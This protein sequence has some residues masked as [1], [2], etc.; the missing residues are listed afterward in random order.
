MRAAWLSLFSTLALAP[1]AFSG[2]GST[3]DEPQGSSAGTGGSSVAGAGGAASGNSASGG[4]GN[5]SGAAASGAGNRAGETGSADCTPDDCGPQLGLPNWVCADGAIG[6]PTGRCIE[7]EGA[8]CGWEVNDCPPAA[9]GGAEG[10]SAGASGGNASGAGG[11]PDA[12]ECS[13]CEPTATRICVHQLG[14]PG[15]GG[16]SCATLTL[17]DALTACGCVQGQG[18]CQPNLMGEPPSYCVCDNGL[19]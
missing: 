18:T 16:F 14:G 1:A 4:G 6:G 8:T 3:G 15:P 5:G 12:S 2:C 7:R 13:G 17:C 10:G 11:A 9:V 19:D